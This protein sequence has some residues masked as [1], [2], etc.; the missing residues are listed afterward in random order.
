MVLA[1]R[2]KRTAMMTLIS[3]VKRRKYLIFWTLVR[4]GPKSVYVIPHN[5]FHASH[6][7]EVLEVSR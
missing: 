4:I 2:R 1:A 6:S 5:T 3:K 7:A